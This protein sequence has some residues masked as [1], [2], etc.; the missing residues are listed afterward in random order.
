MSR[1]HEALKKTAQERSEQ[2]AGRSAQE[3]IA[4]VEA[5]KLDAAPRIEQVVED[6][7]AVT[8]RA[9]FGQREFERFMLKCRQAE[10][11][12]EPR[13]SVFAKGAA[14]KVGVERFGTLRSRLYQ[15]AAAQPLRRILLTSS[16]PEEG[17]TFVS[18]NLAQSF[19]RQT[20]RRV[21][22][23]DADLRISRLHLTLGALKEPGLADYLCDDID[24]TKIIQVGAE[25]NLCFIGGGREV[26]NPSELLHSERMKLLLDKLTP[27]FDW[28]ILDSPPALLVHDASMLADMCDG[29]L[30]VV[31]AG[32]TSFETA[33]KAVLEFRD[34][35]I[36]GV[37][38]NRVE[39]V[40]LYHNYHYGYSGESKQDRPTVGI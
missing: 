12:I 29:V 22:L 16:I 20:G 34:K 26:S 32:R 27:M 1:I 11:R 40:A 28:V 8:P 25:N 21:L 14:H 39:D 24:L 13:Y 3:L 30:F 35:K 33:E 6:R 18:S 7:N 23:I 19:I 4:I 9:E 37:V 15:I 38:L 10:W 5:P 36:L 2:L 17:K 31:R